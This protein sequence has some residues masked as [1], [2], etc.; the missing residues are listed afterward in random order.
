MKESYKSEIHYNKAIARSKKALE[1]TGLEFIDVVK[2]DVS[3]SFKALVEY[4]CKHCGT[5]DSMLLVSIE[6]RTSTK[7]MCKQCNKNSKMKEIITLA[8]PYDITVLDYYS[9]DNKHYYVRYRCNQCNTE[10]E[11]SKRDLI[12]GKLKCKICRKYRQLGVEFMHTIQININDL[13]KARIKYKTF[14]MNI[15][16]ILED[17]MHLED[18]EGWMQI[19]SNENNMDKLCDLLRFNSVRFK[20]DGREPYRDLGRFNGNLHITLEPRNRKIDPTVILEEISKLDIE[21]TRCA[22]QHAVEN[23]IILKLEADEEHNEEYNPFRELQ[24]ILD[25]HEIINEVC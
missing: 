14:N 12:K 7:N 23:N 6:K 8:K 25:E 4:K 13:E 17:M 1:G 22:W 19:K 10:G 15:S 24:D 5:T 3:G 18:S 16:S 11:C 21:V 20:I 9:N 2:K